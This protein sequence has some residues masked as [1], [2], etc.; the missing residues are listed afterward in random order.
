MLR[1][2][3]MSERGK[4][5]RGT[6]GAGGSGRSQRT[7]N[8]RVAVRVSYSANKNPGQWKAHGR[9]VA[10]ESATQGG[11]AA[12]AGFNSTDQNLD[13]AAKLDKWQGAGDERLFKIIVSPEFGDRLNLHQYT[14]ELLQR[15]EHDLGAQLEWVAAVHHNTEHPHVHIA[16]RGVDRKGIPVR[17]PREYIRGGLRGRAEEIATETLGYRSAADAHEAHRRE[18]VQ[19]RYTPLDRIL[20]F[21]ND[22][23]SSH[24]V[25]TVNPEDESLSDSTRQLQKHLLARL[26][27]LQ[28]MGLAQF[29]AQH[30]WSVQAD[31][32]KVLR[33]LQQSGDRQKTLAAHGAL[34]SDKRLPLQVTPLRQLQRVAGRV[35]LHTEDEQTGKRYMLIEG[36][37]AKVHLI[38]HTGAIEQARSE[39]KLAVGSFIRIEKR[40]TD[41]K[42]TLH[43]DDLGDANA[44]LQNSTHFQKEADL[45]LH[46]GVHEV[47]PSWGGWLGQYQTKLQAE[48]GNPERCKQQIFGRG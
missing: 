25:V 13:I 34:L 15:M 12:E 36:T 2:V 45:L 7:F 48:L 8:Q 27:H 14:R 29:V 20:Q 47:Q 3:Q 28:K 31:F 43:V 22:G 23:S 11:K 5:T 6:H 32:E 42:P 1:I 41:K 4:K 46:R 44:L 38:Y 37:D 21:S 39:G 16:L 40:F 10:R 26:M 30:Q 9:Y 18:A 17:L 19:A 33:T 24:F 35:V